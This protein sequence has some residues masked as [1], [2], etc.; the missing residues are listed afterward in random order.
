MAVRLGGDGTVIFYCFCVAHNWIF[1]RRNSR[2][3]G[4]GGVK[5]KVCQSYW[6]DYPKQPIL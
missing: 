1:F 5:M 4:Y 6:T 3:K 2:R